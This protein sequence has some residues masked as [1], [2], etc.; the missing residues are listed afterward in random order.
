MPSVLDLNRCLHY[1]YLDRF[2]PLPAHHFATTPLSTISTQAIDRLRTLTL[3]GL[4]FSHVLI[5]VPIR[6][7]RGLNPITGPPLCR[8]LYPLFKRFGMLPPF[9]FRRIK[10]K[11]PSREEGLS[12]FLHGI[13]SQYI[14]T[15]LRNLPGTRSRRAYRSSIPG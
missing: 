3:F 12:Q 9:Q 5:N 14:S 2:V 13:N 8:R 10:R 6:K 4:Q 1:L 15:A 7:A 11:P